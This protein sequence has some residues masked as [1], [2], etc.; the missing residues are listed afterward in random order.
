[1]RDLPLHQA[2]A[3]FEF[4]NRA[5]VPLLQRRGDDRELFGSG[6]LFEARGTL[7]LITAGHFIARLAEHGNIAVADES[8]IRYV[9]GRFRT[10][11]S[12]ESEPYDIGFIDLTEVRADFARYA[13][14]GL[15]HVFS[16][17]EVKQILIAGFPLERAYPITQEFLRQPHVFPTRLYTGDPNPD[18]VDTAFDPEHHLLFDFPTT[19]YQYLA[20]AWPE[21][22]V[23]CCQGVSG[24]PVW[25]LLPRAEGAVW[26]PENA[27]RLVAIQSSQVKGRFLRA[28]RW[29]SVH[30]A[31]LTWRPEL[32][33]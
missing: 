21:R 26:S 28:T 5:T 14:L 30:G 10:W 8:H 25:G 24:G 15:R 1:M 17:G 31:L 33:Q 29:R 20:G 23:S 7:I 16:G 4:L 2:T 11:R 22:P 6:T 19:A 18:G 27:G 3:F 32:F 13:P 12:N 9:P